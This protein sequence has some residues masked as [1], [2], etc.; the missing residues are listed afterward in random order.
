LKEVDSLFFLKKLIIR[1]NENNNYSIG[2]CYTCHTNSARWAPLL[3]V[4]IKKQEIF[5][6]MTLGEVKATIRLQSLWPIRYKI[7]EI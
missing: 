6:S 3:T 5:I 7:N 4:Y 1:Y 2:M